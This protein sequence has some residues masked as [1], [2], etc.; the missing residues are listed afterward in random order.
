[1]VCHLDNFE[2]LMAGAANLVSTL[3][4]PKEQHIYK[5]F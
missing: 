3:P 2:E 5:L 4:P 1:M